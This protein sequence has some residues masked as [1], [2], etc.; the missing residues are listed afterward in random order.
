MTL[1]TICP[2]LFVA[3]RCDALEGGEWTVLASIRGELC[4]YAR[5]SF[6][7]TLLAACRGICYLLGQWL[8]HAHD[9]SAKLFQK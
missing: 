2:S 9:K 6:D 4:L 8:V 5:V 1:A 7:A 3:V